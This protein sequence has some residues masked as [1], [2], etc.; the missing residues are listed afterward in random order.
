MKP[1]SERRD[2]RDVEARTVEAPAHRQRRN[3]AVVARSSAVGRRDL[4]V[5]ER[6]EAIDQHQRADRGKDQ[7][8]E[9]ADDDIDLPAST[10]APG[11]GPLR[12]REPSEPAGDHHR[13][14]LNVD[15]AAAHVDH[16]A[17]HAGAGDL[18][19][20]RGHR[21]GRRDAVE[22]QQRS[23]QEPA[24]DAEHS[25][26]QA[27]DEAE[28]DD[29]DGVDRLAGDREVDVHRFATSSRKR[30]CGPSWRR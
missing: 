4:E 16:R 24:A 6:L 9:Q 30:R 25:G 18:G 10:E 27:D 20:G 1:S 7:H 2:G 8:V 3:P 29:E 13:R 5:S 23:G 28:Q 14:H 21:H 12:S 22:D 17:R 11:T 15:A 19:R 26:Q